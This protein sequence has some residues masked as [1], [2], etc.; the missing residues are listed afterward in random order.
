M[1]ILII[2][3]GMFVVTYIPRVLPVLIHNRIT[4]PVWADNWLKSI[5]YAALGALIFPGIININ[6]E[7]QIAGIISGI[8][9]SIAAYFNLNIAYVIGSAILVSIVI[10]NFNK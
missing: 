4:L 9:A 2:T 3:I 5:P 1:K 8:T 10:E 7:N 6:K